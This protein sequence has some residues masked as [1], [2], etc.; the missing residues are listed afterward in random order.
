MVELNFPV[1]EVRTH[2]LIFRG[3]HGAQ[4]HWWCQPDI[5]FLLAFSMTKRE[6]SITE[7]IHDHSIDGGDKS[8]LP[9]EEEEDG[10]VYDDAGN[11]YRRVPEQRLLQRMLT[12]R[13]V[14]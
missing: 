11:A 2:L 7:D 8:A 1:V 4:I 5:F 13:F 10:T 12:S 14:I 3:C 9:D 6:I